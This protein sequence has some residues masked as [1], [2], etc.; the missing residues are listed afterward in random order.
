M[1]FGGILA[2]LRRQRG[3]SQEVLALRAAMLQR[4]L[5][6][7]ETGRAQP[8]AR[9]ISKLAKALA[10]RAWEQRTLVDALAPVDR[11]PVPQPP[12]DRVVSDLIQRFSQWP[13]YV[14]RAD[15]TLVATNPGLDRLLT[16]AEPQTD[17]W[18]KT[19]PTGG[20]NIYDLVFH[21]DGLCRHM[22][23]PHEVIPETLRRL[24][25]EAAQDTALYDV[26]QRV[27]GYPSVKA[28]AAAPPV[29]PPI[30]VERYV[31]GTA[32]LSIISILSHLAS[33]GD[34]ALG[35]L[36]IETFVPADEASEQLLI[37]A[38]H[39]TRDTGH[40]N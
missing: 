24:R 1:S 8:S 6:F 18:A 31:L 30:L 21:P 38:R 23:N 33:P 10:L 9:A 22:V 25:I 32:T 20:P 27:E 4:H 28:W 3:W 15:G 34:V 26:L 11:P 7:L 12:T 40:L 19:A 36:R 17:V 39:L 13:A 2:R 29:P 37:D 35:L 14:Y 16:V 5:S